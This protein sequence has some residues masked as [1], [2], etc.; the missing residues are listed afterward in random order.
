M[1]LPALTNFTA[2]VNGSMGTIVASGP[3]TCEDDNLMPLTEVTVGTGNLAS[4]SSAALYLTAGQASYVDDTH[5]C[6]G[7]SHT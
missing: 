3:S 4:Q 7:G 1:F 2:P 5:A 6:S